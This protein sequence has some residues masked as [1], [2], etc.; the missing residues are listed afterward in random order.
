M[1]SYKKSSKTVIKIERTV[2]TQQVM[3]IDR[4]LREKTGNG[5]IEAVKSR[6][7]QKV[8]DFLQVM[9]SLKTLGII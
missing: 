6:Y 3:G 8:K 2:T 4:S 7:P 1:G 5:I 9:S